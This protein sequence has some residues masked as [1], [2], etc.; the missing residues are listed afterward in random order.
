MRHGYRYA[1]TAPTGRNFFRLHLAGGWIE[2]DGIESHHRVEQS[3]RL[4]R[5][6]RL[7]SC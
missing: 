2:R 3:R 1:L 4:D 6:R 5:A 7:L